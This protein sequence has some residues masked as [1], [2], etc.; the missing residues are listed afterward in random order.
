MTQIMLYMPVVV[1]PTVR[2]LA[3]CRQYV[4]VSDLH[5]SFSILLLKAIS[6]I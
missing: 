1:R 6:L 3:V 5:R 4:P 2:M